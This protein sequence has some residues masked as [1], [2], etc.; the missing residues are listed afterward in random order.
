MRGK[1]SVKQVRHG[2]RLPQLRVRN[3]LRALDAVRDASLVSP[4]EYSFLTKA[5]VFLRDVENKLQMVND[6][7]THSLPRDHVQLTTC[8]RL[9][10]YGDA[11]PLLRDYQHHTGNVHLIFERRFSES[12]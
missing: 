10:G 3:T 7:Q 9:L 11:E 2:A 12:N 1:L 6:A 5:Y 8:A 4:E